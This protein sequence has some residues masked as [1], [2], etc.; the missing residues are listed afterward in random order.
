MTYQS[1]IISVGMP[2]YNGE[3][4]LA[5]SIE[6]ILTQSFTDFEL[7]ISD[8][9][10]SD[11]TEEICRDFAARDPRIRYFRQDTNFGAPR[12][13]NFVFEQARGTFFKWSSSNDLCRPDFLRLCFAALKDRPDAVLSYPRTLLISDDINKGEVYADNMD[14]QDAQAADRFN[15]ILENMALNNVM[16]GLIRC[17]ALRKTRMHEVYLCSDFV[18]MAEL[19][20]LGKFIEV[21]D[22]LFLR[23]LDEASSTQMMSEQQ[24]SK[25]WDPSV[26]VLPATQTWRLYGGYITAIIRAP[27]NLG[28][29]LRA[30]KAVLRQMKWDRYKLSAEILLVVGLTRG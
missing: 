14:L 3:T 25:H 17:D 5:A 19:A 6:S 30:F 7:I 29:K 26:E 21:P 24:A 11:G 10:S 27:V 22:D 12:N 4:W 28:N 15:R 18:L 8:N 2:V 23:R 16:N 9:A 13:Y 1:P 20:L